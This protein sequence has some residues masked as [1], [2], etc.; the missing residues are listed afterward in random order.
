MVV[1]F[2]LYFILAACALAALAV[3]IF[4]IGQA[5]TECPNTGRAAKAGSLTIVSGFATI[6]AGGILLIAALVVVAVPKMT[7]PGL[8]GALGL[9]LLCLGLGF[10]Q[11]VASLR[12]V[13]AQAAKAVAGTAKA[14]EA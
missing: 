2:I 10:T 1:Y 3:M 9:A 6:G 13:V 8:M 14:A 11:A 4:R 5:L 12:D 7:V